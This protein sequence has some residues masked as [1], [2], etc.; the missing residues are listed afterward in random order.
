LSL[1]DVIRDH[2]IH[3]VG[4]DL[5]LLDMQAP[6]EFTAFLTAIADRVLPGLK[7][8]SFDHNHMN[9][10]QTR[11]FLQFLEKQPNIS[12]LSLDCGIDI[13]D[14]P[15]GLTAFLNI[16]SNK[17]IKSLSLQGDASLRYSFG[18]LASAV[19]SAGIGG[20]GSDA[21]RDG[22][23]DTDIPSSFGA[24]KGEDDI[25]ARFEQKGAGVL[26]AINPIPA[27]GIY[28]SLGTTKAWSNYAAGMPAEAALGDIFGAGQ[29]ALAYAI[30]GVGLF[31]AQFVGGT[32]GKWL[33]YNNDSIGSYTVTDQICDASAWNKLQFAF[34]YTG[35]E[36]LTIDV[37]A[38][39]PLAITGEKW[40]DSSTPEDESADTYTAGNN[41]KPFKVND[42]QIGKDDKYQAPINIALGAKYASGPLAVSLRLD[43]GFGG[44]TTISPALTRDLKLFFMPTS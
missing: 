16:L 39:I 20:V 18:D 14:S 35:M 19:L 11:T 26:F 22:T 38:N 25:F 36:G 42:N 43:L 41:V 31:R 28:A 23:A 10:A 3:L 29:Y 12:S 1:F 8:F 7:L 33:Y 34:A 6:E 2:S 5:G 21:D 30:D 13:S 17:R 15:A 9:S 40:D 44:K 27:L 37:G 32:Y 24:R 4:L